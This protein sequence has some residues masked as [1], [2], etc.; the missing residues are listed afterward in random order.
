MNNQSL[1][2][3]QQRPV[4]PVKKPAADAGLAQAMDDVNRMP[5]A[6]AQAAV[7]KAK[8]RQ[9][10]VL[11]DAAWVLTVCGFFG[12]VFVASSAFIRFFL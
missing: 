7:A 9:P 2:V 8:R 11:R 3:G 1:Y 12:A 6:V 4:N 10:S 5:V